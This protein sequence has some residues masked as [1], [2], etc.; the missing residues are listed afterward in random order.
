MKWLGRRK[1]A[2]GCKG[3]VAEQKWEAIAKCDLIKWE[4]IG[5]LP[6]KPKQKKFW[7]SAA[8]QW[9][10]DLGK[11]DEGPVLTVSY[12]DIFLSFFMEHTFD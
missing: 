6:E 11:T 2:S 12:I 3:R 1:V 7:A 10:M 5:R 4:G 8:L 9:E